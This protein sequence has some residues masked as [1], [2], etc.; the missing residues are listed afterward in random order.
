M[1]IGLV[2]YQGSGKTTLFEWLTGVDADPS[3]SHT[4]QSAMAAVPEPRVE[5]LCQVYKP[6][7][8]TL[9]SLELVDTP[10]LARTHE[11]N[12]ARLALIRDTG[13]LVLV[14]AGFAARDPL[15]DLRT[16]GEDAL[17]ADMEIVTGRIERL[18]ESSRKPR[19]N[20]EQ[21]A[22]ELATLEQVLSAME[23]GTPLAASNMT[24]EQFKATRSFRLLSEKPT[25]VIVNAADD[26]TNFERFGPSDTGGRP[27]LAV[28]VGL[29]RELQRMS[30]ED[31]VEFEREMNLGPSRH[32]EVLRKI[33][34]VSGQML[35]FTAGEKEVRTWMLNQG[36]TALEAAANIH[37][38]L[39]RG[40]IR[41]EVMTCRDLVRLGSEREVKANNLARQEP[42]DYVVRDDDILNIKF[43]V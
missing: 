15:V 6:K 30:P 18:R 27:V 41:A 5:A 31:R 7:K 9:A 38:D 8:I 10:G 29:E 20:R 17:L 23:A 1:K 24:D 32:D 16:F 26:E 40:F 21:E 3:K 34:D 37:S 33:L 2:G 14:V 39:A 36:G 42:K 4:G 11:G 35:Y 25:L 28:R 12:P 19:P 43:S 13:C 22:A